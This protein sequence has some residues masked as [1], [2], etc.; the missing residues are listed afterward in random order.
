MGKKAQLYTYFQYAT[1]ISIRSRNTFAAVK[2]WA[3]V[4]FSILSRPFQNAPRSHQIC[5]LGSRIS[6]V[7]DKS[8]RGLSHS[9]RSATFQVVLRYDSSP[10]KLFHLKNISRSAL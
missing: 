1:D 4:T 6:E 9:K 3:L 7:C 5:K 2:K 10:H 8:E